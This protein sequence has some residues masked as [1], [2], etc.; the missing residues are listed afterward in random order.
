[1]QWE[2]RIVRPSDEGPHVLGVPYFDMILKTVAYSM[3][4]N[5]YDSEREKKEGEEYTYLWC[6]ITKAEPYSPLG[7]QWDPLLFHQLTKYVRTRFDEFKP[8]FKLMR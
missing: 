8:L 3:V 4:W 6:K 1:M 2:E 7:D 5:G